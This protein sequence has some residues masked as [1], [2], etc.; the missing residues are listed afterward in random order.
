MIRNPTT[1]ASRPSFQVFCGWSFMRHGWTSYPS[2]PPLEGLL[3]GT[4]KLGARHRS[5]HGNRSV[6][7]GPWGTTIIYG[8]R[9]YIEPCSGCLRGARGRGRFDEVISQTGEL[10]MIPDRQLPAMCVRF[11]P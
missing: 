8:F 6:P 1:V 11:F 7:P 9:A 3:M 5:Q 2:S 4:I 10:Q